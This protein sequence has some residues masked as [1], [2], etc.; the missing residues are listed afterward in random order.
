VAS[1]P[2]FAA[3]ARD[4]VVA[5]RAVP[6]FG[7]LAACRAVTLLGLPA[8]AVCCG[9]SAEGLPLAVQVVGR[10]FADRE[11]V[12]VAVALDARLG[13]RRTPGAPGILQGVSEREP[14]RR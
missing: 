9:V 8:A 13:W 4:F 12:A 11:V 1:I 2:A 10:P 7:I 6:R 5:G 3:G 14:G